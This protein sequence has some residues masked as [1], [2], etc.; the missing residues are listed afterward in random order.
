MNIIITNWRLNMR[1]CYDTLY[2]FNVNKC[3]NHSTHELILTLFTNIG[4][5][6][7]EKTN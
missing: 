4:I 3:L 5:D 7:T 2:I 6:D 1:G